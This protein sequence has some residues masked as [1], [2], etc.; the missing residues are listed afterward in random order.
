MIKYNF[1]AILTHSPGVLKY[2][3]EKKYFFRNQFQ[4]LV[5]KF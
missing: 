2:A 4:F 1:Q 5:L 3:V